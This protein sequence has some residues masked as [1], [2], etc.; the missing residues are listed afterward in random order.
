[1]I[2]SG[3][4]HADRGV[5]RGTQLFAEPQLVSV[6]NLGLSVR[7]GPRTRSRPTL[8]SSTTTS[9]GPPRSPSTCLSSPRLRRRARVPHPTVQGGLDA[10]AEHLVSSTSHRSQ[11]WS[12]ASSARRLALWAV[13]AASRSSRRA[14]RLAATRDDAG[15]TDG[16]D[17]QIGSRW[18]SDPSPARAELA[19]AFSGLVARSAPGLR[20]RCY[21]GSGVL[22][23]VGLGVPAGYGL[24]TFDF[25]GRRL[26]LSRR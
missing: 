23:A 16:P 12:I 25:F 17:S 20:T 14:D 24:A 7:C 4:L 2:K 22:I 18:A 21:S 10:T 13:L 1:M 19:G 5:R 8:R 6:A 9:T 3:H 11:P 15:G 26:L